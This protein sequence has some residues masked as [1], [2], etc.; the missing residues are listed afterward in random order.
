MQQFVVPQ[1]IDVEDKVIGPITV[2]Q[3]VILLIAGGLV[4]LAYKGSDF[5]LFLFWFFL[6]IILTVVFAFIK[7]NG[8]PVH[9]F[10]LNFLQTMK[11]PRL[12]LWNK[13]LNEFQL[14]QYLVQP[15]EEA[16]VR[17][18]RKAAVGSSRLAELSLIVD[19]GGVYE[20]EDVI[21][22]R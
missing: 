3:F 11:R 17:R 12:R 1:F 21:P 22:Q 16:V 19:T 4:F 9:Y 20:G 2:R 13:R 10:I 7:I 15:P 14:K 6:I 5:T 18:P 8:R